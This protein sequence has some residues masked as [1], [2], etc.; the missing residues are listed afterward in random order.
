VRI[1]LEYYPPAGGIGA[2]LSSLLG[3]RPGGI[4]EEALRRF[5]Q[6]HEAGAIARKENRREHTVMVS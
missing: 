3:K 5:K 1:A 4:V 2:G 6:L